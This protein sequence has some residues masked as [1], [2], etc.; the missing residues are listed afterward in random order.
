MSFGDAFVT[1][2][3]IV[4]LGIVL[5]VAAAIIIPELIRDP[6]ARRIWGF[7][8]AVLGSFLIVCTMLALVILWIAS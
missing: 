1:S 8:T 5:A 7:F 4:G 2:L 6:E 3:A